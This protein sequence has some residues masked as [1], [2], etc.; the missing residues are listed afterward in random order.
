MYNILNDY[1]IHNQAEIS[2]TVLGYRYFLR[3][4]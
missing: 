2:K 1:G 4:Q 3:E